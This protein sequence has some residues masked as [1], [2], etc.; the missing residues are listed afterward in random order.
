MVAVE[1]GD[2]RIFGTVSYWRETYRR[3]ANAVAQESLA[4]GRDLRE[5]TIACL[6]GGYGVSAPIGL[7]A[8]YHLRE[9]G[10]TEGNPRSVDELRR[11]LEARL[12]VGS[13]PVH[14]RFARQRAER[15]A[16]AQL[17]FAEHPLAPAEPVALRDW[18]LQID[19][20][21]MKTA[22][23]IVR[24]RTQSDH[25]AVL[26]IHILRACGAIGVFPM[27]YSLARDYRVLE[28]RF[29][30]FASSIGAR[31]SVLDAIMWSQMR[32]RSAPVGRSTLA[33]MHGLGAADSQAPE[34][35]RVV[36]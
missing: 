7:A 17:F 22:S 6:L 24:N 5:E 19:G 35:P 15:I 4:L 20:V 30:L 12:F 2:P 14:Y 13:R 33:S 1:W 23:W 21:G 8:Y 18:L 31:A 36:S 11:A 26:D 34:Q 3:Q 9:R 28:R 25:I 29:V 16:S 32:L 27:R 10:L